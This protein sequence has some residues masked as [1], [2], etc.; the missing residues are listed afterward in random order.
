MNNSVFF[1]FDKYN[2]KD[3]YINLVRYNAELMTKSQN[4]TANIQGN[5]DD[6]GSVEYN[7]SLGQ[8]RA[9]AIKKVLVALGV[10]SGSIEASSNGK[11]R[12]KFDNNTVEGRSLNRRSDI[13]FKNESSAY[14]DNNGL[15]KLK[16]N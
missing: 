9:D 13:F 2:I 5:T 4:I 14:I 12:S 10:N 11:L 7:L 3:D 15:P 6:I 1:D 16:I 8:R